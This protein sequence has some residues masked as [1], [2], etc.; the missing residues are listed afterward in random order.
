MATHSPITAAAISAWLQAEAGVHRGRADGAAQE[1]AN[2]W[3]EQDLDYQTVKDILGDWLTNSEP[4]P[5]NLA[6]PLAERFGL[7]LT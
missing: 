4:R 1:L 3:N 5:K 2:A 6:D 7:T